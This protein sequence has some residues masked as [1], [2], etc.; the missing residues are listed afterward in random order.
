MVPEVQGRF[1]LLRGVGNERC[2][3]VDDTIGETAMASMFQ[4]AS[5]LELI[6]DGLD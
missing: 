1:F 5:V 4:L 6:I 2:Q 3:Y